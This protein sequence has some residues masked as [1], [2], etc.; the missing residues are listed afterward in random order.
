ML[1]D[2]GFE[3]E[4]IHAANLYCCG[5]MTL[6]G[7]PH[8]KVEH[9]PVFDCA[10][11]CGRIGTRSLPIEA[12]LHMMA[13]AQPFVS[14]AIS[15]TVNMPNQASVEDCA[16]AYMNAWRLGLKSIALYRDGSKLSQP[17]S[18]ML[19]ANDAD[20]DE[21]FIE[22][23]VDA[24]M[25]DKS[26]IVAERIVERII[27]RTP[28]R[29]RLPDR[30]KGYIQKA[31][32]G[33]HKVY[34]HTGE[35]D[36]GEIGEVFIDMHKEGAAFRSLMNNFAIAV[37]L[38]LQ[39]GVPLEEFVDAYVFTR[40]DP[41][42]PVQGNDQ[43]KH[44]TSI[45]DYIFREL[46][47]SYLG[48][49]DLAHMDPQESSVDAIGR[50]VQGE[51]V[52]EEAARLISKGFS[53]ST[54]SDNLVVLR[55][56]EFDRMRKSAGSDENFNNAP[57]DDDTSVSDFAANDIVDIDAEDAIDSG[58]DDNDS[59]LDPPE[60]EAQIAKLAE[61]VNQ[62][63]PPGILSEP[64]GAAK[65]QAKIKG[66]EGDACPDCGQFTLVRNGACLRCDS[67]GASTGC[68]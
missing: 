42:G 58:I 7:A 65:I 63:V 1:R 30:R 4:E 13:A 2:I 60:I 21:A 59:S 44:A 49:T 14:G 62:K 36:D 45:L 64:G 24:P 41:S 31:I 9:L 46:A 18:T 50:G 27:E 43:I 48:R 35:F 8:L 26:K 22:D 68:S 16:G 6:E 38:G 52:Q 54:V 28:G 25:A 47:I 67:C 34:L 11:P 20:D 51:K 3:D 37:S 61:A 10:N 23:F 40:F 53:R 39:Y 19:L 12:H 29:R 33:G 66:Y 55:G 56:G 15:K 32:V 17:L 57:D 5:A